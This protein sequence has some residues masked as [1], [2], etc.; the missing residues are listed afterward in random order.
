MATLGVKGLSILGNSG[1]L[2]Y[3][4]TVVCGGTFR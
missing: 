4:H 2:S 1:A 3:R